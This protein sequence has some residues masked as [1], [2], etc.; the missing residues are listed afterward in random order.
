MGVD[1]QFALPFNN[2]KWAVVAEPNYSSFSGSD[3]KKRSTLKYSYIE[4]PIGVRHRFFLSSKSYI[5][6]NGMISFD[7]S[8]DFNQTY[9]I[10]AATSGALV[11]NRTVVNF[12]AGAGFSYSRFSIEGRYYPT[13]KIDYEFMTQTLTRSVVILGFRVL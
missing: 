9:P 1:L 5:F 2:G 8:K 13:R 7:F 12:T 4:I 10:T 6:V 3:T 11:D